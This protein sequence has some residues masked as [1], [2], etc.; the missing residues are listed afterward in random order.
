V[1]GPAHSLPRDEP[2][3]SEP[4]STVEAALQQLMAGHGSPAS[5]LTALLDSDLHVCTGAGPG[6]LFTSP[7]A[8]G[9]DAVDACTFEALVPRH[10]AGTT[11]MT[12]RALAAAAAGHDLRLTAGTASVT[13]PVDD[14][15]GA[16]TPPG[17]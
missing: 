2:E 5:L 17:H 3:S 15:A 1:A 12:G 4:P 9:R 11:V 6:W 16:M 13:F 7:G 14:L 10:W 8:N